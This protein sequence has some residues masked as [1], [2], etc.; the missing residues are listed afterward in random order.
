[1]PCRGS[2]K[3]QFG[4]AYRRRTDTFDAQPNDGGVSAELL[5][6]VTGVASMVGSARLDRI[7]ELLGGSTIA[8]G[9]SAG[10]N[11]P[12]TASTA[13][14]WMEVGKVSLLDWLALTWS[15]GWTR[16]P[17][18]SANE[19]TPRS[20]SCCCWCPNLSG[21]SAGSGR[22]VP[23]DDLVGGRRDGVRLIR[24]MIRVGVDRCRSLL[25]AGHRDDVRGL[26]C[27][28]R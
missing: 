16:T 1:M 28:S 9:R 7:R 12:V 18:R 23:L 25:D 26:E 15:L 14:T 11:L 27:C 21:T 6:S 19:Q 10:I 5:P 2:A 8:P 20:C 22:G 4:H 3:R 24:R 13:A 17:V